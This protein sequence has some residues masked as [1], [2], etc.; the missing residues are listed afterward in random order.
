[1]GGYQV[2]SFNPT[3]ELP[4]NVRELYIGKNIDTF[5]INRVGL[6]YHGA[7]VEYI[8]VDPQHPT[9]TSYKGVVYNI[10]SDEPKYIPAGMKTIEL[11]PM[12]SI[13]KNLIYGNNNVEV[14]VVA[15]GTQSIEN[16]AFEKCPNL[17]TAYVPKN[18]QVADNAF[19]DV[20]PDFQIIRTE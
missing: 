15:E 5:G 11:L 2:T 6:N 12:K 14:V 9:L 1:V 8:N 17:K 19:F 13:G 18:V 10:G 16:W 7:N 4:A 3:V 20:H